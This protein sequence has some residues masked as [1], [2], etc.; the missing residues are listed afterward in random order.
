MRAA[1]IYRTLLCC[2]PAAFRDEYG[3]DMVD[4]FEQQLQ[5]ATQRDGWRGGATIWIGTLYD[6]PF[7]APKEHWHVIY[8]DLRHA[9]RILAR[10]RDSPSPPCSCSHSA[11]APTA[12]SSAWSTT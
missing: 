12:R 5:D 11:S 7:T 8:Q 9:I 6:L 1:D 10:T 3:H 4:T 2:Y